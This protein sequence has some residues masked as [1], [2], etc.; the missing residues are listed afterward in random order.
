M[1][2]LVWNTFNMDQQGT[3]SFEWIHDTECDVVKRTGVFNI[4]ALFISSPR[5]LH[6][7]RASQRAQRHFIWILFTIS[8]STM[9]RI[10]HNLFTVHHKVHLSFNVNSTL[11]YVFTSSTL[12]KSTAIA[13]C[14]VCK[15]PM[16]SWHCFERVWFFFLLTT[17][18]IVM[19]ATV[20][21]CLIP[22]FLV[23]AF[24][25]RLITTETAF[26]GHSKR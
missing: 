21:N 17:D 20:A 3:I 6:W 18:R 25:E 7:F 12:Q 4:T 5:N 24:N 16:D 26:A 8:C 22:I 14:V 15:I 11:E 13:K 9:A 10:N 19:T 1:S 23:T 2:P